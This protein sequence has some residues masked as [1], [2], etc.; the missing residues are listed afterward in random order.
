[1]NQAALRRLAALE[2]SGTFLRILEV[3][4][5]DWRFGGHKAIL[6]GMED[7]ILAPGR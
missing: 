2:L 7:H 4:V 1:M 3:W 6:D 5:P